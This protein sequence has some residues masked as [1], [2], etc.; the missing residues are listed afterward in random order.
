MCNEIE[1]AVEP[2]WI[3]GDNA[4]TTVYAQAY[5]SNFTIIFSFRPNN[6]V[7]DGARSSSL[8]HRSQ[9]IIMIH[10]VRGKMLA[11]PTVQPCGK[12]CGGLFEKSGPSALTFHRRVDSI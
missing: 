3:W 5:D 2:E 8:A 4:E 10:E 6:V 11:S 9:L 12:S 7:L 1:A